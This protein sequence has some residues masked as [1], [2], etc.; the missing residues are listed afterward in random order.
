MTSVGG[1]SGAMNISAL[2][3]SVNVNRVIKE[4]STSVTIEGAGTFRYEH[5]VALVI[6]I[7]LS[8][9]APEKYDVGRADSLRRPL[10]LV[11]VTKCLFRM[12]RPLIYA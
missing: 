6:F 8:K 1:N 2:N 11:P 9:T 12:A 7:S 4:G 5:W 3:Y 10:A